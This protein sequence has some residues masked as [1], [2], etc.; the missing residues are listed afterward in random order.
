MNAHVRANRIVSVS[1][2]KTVRVWD[3]KNNHKLLITIDLGFLGL[4]LEQV[5]EWV[6]AVGGESQL[7]PFFDIMTGKKRREEKTTFEQVVELTN[8]GGELFVTSEKREMRVY[9]CE[10]MRV[11]K[12]I[13][14]F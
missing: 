9:S 13:R 4:V 12:K 11:I 10:T 2:D 1:V 8:F 3:L 5:H 14:Y 7:L 6:F